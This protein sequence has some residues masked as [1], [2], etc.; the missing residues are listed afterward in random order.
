[1]KDMMQSIKKKDNILSSRTH[2]NVDLK[3]VS[4][5]SVAVYLIVGVIWTFAFK[6]IL[7][8]KKII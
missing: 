5:F 7:H 6:N 4:I 8:K 1:M 2:P 3:W